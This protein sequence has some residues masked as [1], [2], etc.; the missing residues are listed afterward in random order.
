METD[1]STPRLVARTTPPAK[2]AAGQSLM[3]TA[4]DTYMFDQ[5]WHSFFP[6]AKTEEKKWIPAGEYVSSW[7][8]ASW[9]FEMRDYC[10]S[11]VLIRTGLQANA[12]SIFGKRTGDKRLSVTSMQAYSM[13]LHEVHRCLEDPERR[14]QDSLLAACKLLALYEV[15]SSPD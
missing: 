8:P 7:I 4:V 10:A 14:T 2:Y 12:Y 9:I 6:K 15:C 11:D 1:L 13:V 3:N 5:Y